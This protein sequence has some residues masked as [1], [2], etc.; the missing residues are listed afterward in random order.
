[1][2]LNELEHEAVWYLCDPNKDTELG[3]G[4]TYRKF[5]AWAK[6]FLAPY[7]PLECV[8]EDFYKDVFDEIINN[9]NTVHQLP[10]GHG[11]TEITGIW[12]T[13]YL[14]VYQPRNKFF[15]LRKK[16]SSKRIN[17]QLILAGAA[18]DLNAW[19][20][21]IKYFFDVSPALQK[22]KPAGAKTDNATRRWNTKEMLLNNGHKLHLRT[23]KSRIRGLHVDRVIADD[24]ITEASTLTDRQTIE[25]WDGAVDGVTTAKEA[26]VNVIGTPLRF[27]DIQYHLKQ[28]TDG[29]FF[30]R[31]PALNKKNEPLS[32]KRKTYEDLM[33]I[34]A[35]I[36]SNKF[37]SEYLLDPLDDGTAIIKRKWIDK[38][39]DKEL[40][41]GYD[42]YKDAKDII[43]VNDTSYLGCDFAFGDK[44][45]NDKSAFVG[46]TIKD[47]IKTIREIHTYKGLS[48]LEQ[49]EIINNLHKK[50][51]YEEVVLEENSIKSVSKELYI[52]QFPYYLIWTGATD[53]AA[54]L[55]PEIQF[56]EKRHTVGKKAMIFRL[57]TE[58]EN[59]NIRM[60]YKT[61]TDQHKTDM[62][63]QE[64][65]T[66]VLEEGK[67]IEVGQHA[68][69]PIGLAMAL[70]RANSS[71]FA[72]YL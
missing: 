35:R 51:P 50:Q 62:L 57:A 7:M 5:I 47:G 65:I 40:S 10:R 22:F 70:E 64:L 31:R 11:K 15:S 30:K 56:Q 36:G 19:T 33:R 69:I 1:M 17:E 53:S 44:A 67:L 16:G 68:D 45:I 32:P 38:C 63:I 3:K 26:M 28:K 71:T 52:Y 2:E 18:D 34:K 20:L 14:A 66:F 13:I 59:G 25:I 24:L 43:N 49:F 61:T 48:I 27:T 54:R 23:M 72:L 9:Q 8:V 60:P 21:R 4:M 41:Y 12:L 55:K 37:S 42:E 39:L 29:Y 58:F 6:T 46:I